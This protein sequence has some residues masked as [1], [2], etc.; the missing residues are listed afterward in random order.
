MVTWPLFGTLQGPISTKGAIFNIL[1]N[2]PVINHNDFQNLVSREPEY[3]RA[4]GYR[5]SEPSNWP[6]SARWRVLR[7][8]YKSMYFAFFSQLGKPSVYHTP[9][10]LRL[11]FYDVIFSLVII[12]LL[13]H[14][15][16]SED[17]SLPGA[18]G[19]EEACRVL[20]FCL[21]PFFDRSDCDQR[22]QS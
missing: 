2:F 18:K 21:G 6:V 14:C 11:Q 15:L 19:A 22:S 10:R 9:R 7:K 5:T 1:T 17:F 8:L 20:P 16:M 13:G 12:R 4:C 3:G